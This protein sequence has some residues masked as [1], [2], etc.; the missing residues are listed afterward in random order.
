MVMG[1]DLPFSGELYRFFEVLAPADYRSAD[2]DAADDDL[3]NGGREFARRQADESY[4][5]AAPYRSPGGKP[6]PME[7]LAVPHGLPRRFV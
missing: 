4:G 1:T 2:S 7:Q 6:A 5:S 3:E